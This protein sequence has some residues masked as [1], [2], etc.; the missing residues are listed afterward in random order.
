M[1]E[2]SIR[3][4]FGVHHM[5]YFVFDDVVVM[6]GANLEEQYFLN[7]QDRYWVFAD[8]PQMANYLE[9]LTQTLLGNS[10]QQSLNQASRNTQG[11]SAMDYKTN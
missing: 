11:T 5:K 9:D 10:E 2:G 7:R 4:V 8:H 6:T 3:E 1:D